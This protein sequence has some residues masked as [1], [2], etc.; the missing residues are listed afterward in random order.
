MRMKC[1]FLM[2]LLCSAT[3]FASCNKITGKI[4][5]CNILP[6]SVVYY[7]LG[8]SMSEVLFSPSKVTCYTIK[9]K[10]T[11]TEEDY[12]VEPHFVRDSLVG[13]LNASEIAVLQF[14]LLSDKEN[15]KEDSIKVRSPYVPCVEFCFEKKKQEAVHVV[16]SLSD[17]SWTLIYDD[18]RQGNWNYEDKRL[19][20]RYC[21]KIIGEP[22]NKIK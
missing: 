14:N 16:I 11:L 1:L 2:S 4:E 6:D 13:K 15:Y 5:K 17:F 19:M 18:K 22:L 10:P 9:G 21:K 7:T 20:E 8:K 3:S 12:E